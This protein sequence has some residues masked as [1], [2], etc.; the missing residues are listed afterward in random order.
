MFNILACI[1]W[2][3][4]NT[5]VGAQLLHAVNNDVPGFAGVLII[6]IATFFVTLFGYKIVHA[7]EFW[8]WIPCFIV[9]LIILGEFAH[10]GVSRYY[11]SSNSYTDVDPHRNSQTSQWVLAA[12]K[13][14]LSCLLQHLSLDMQRVGPATLPTTRATSPPQSRAPKSSSRRFAV[15]PSHCYLP[16]CSGR[17]L[18][19]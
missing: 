9:F 3:C 2:S 15:S 18:C 17:L 13:L 10:S 16:R 19:E 4:V 1:G 8:S 14:V 12:P 5:I 11:Q 7:Y 6:A